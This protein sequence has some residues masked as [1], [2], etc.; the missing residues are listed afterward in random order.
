MYPYCRERIK[1]VSLSVITTG[2]LNR[3]GIKPVH[4]SITTTGPQKQSIDDISKVPK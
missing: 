3:N 2:P 1:P 4:L